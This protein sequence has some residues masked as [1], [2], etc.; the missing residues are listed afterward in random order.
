[1]DNMFVGNAAPLG[2]L[3]N[4]ECYTVAILWI[5]AGANLITGS[6]MTALDALGRELLFND[7]ALDV[8]T[9][10]RSFPCNRHSTR[11]AVRAEEIVVGRGEAG[12]RRLRHVA[13]AATW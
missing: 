5:G 8:R 6:N 2:G 9:S 11:V 10:R 13:A 7:E 1:M 12:G 3:S 4:V